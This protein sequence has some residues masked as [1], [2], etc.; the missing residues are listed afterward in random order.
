MLFRAEL[1]QARRPVSRIAAGSSEGIR[2]LLCWDADPDTAAHPRFWFCGASLTISNAGRK[3]RKWSE[4]GGFGARRPAATLEHAKLGCN[5]I[6]PR[7]NFGK[8]RSFHDK[9]QGCERG[10]GTATSFARSTYR[11]GARLGAKW[12]PGTF[13]GGNR[14]TVPCDHGS[15]ELKSMEE[16]WATKRQTGRRTKVVAD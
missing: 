12:V 16:Q 13:A 2:G 14:S 5:R 8:F 4:A 3:C 9:R 10:T 15:S 1:L 6:D 7:K 11:K